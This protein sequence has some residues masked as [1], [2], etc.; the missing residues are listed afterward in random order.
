MSI[1]IPQKLAGEAYEI[2]FLRELRVALKEAAKPQQKPSEARRDLGR[3][4]FMEP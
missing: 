3:F 1:H 2:P 4:F